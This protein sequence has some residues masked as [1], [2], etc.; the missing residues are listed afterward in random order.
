MNKEKDKDGEGA[1]RYSYLR[2]LKNRLEFK[3]STEASSLSKEKEMIREISSIN[4]ELTALSA[5]VRMDRK[6]GLVKGDIVECKAKLAELEPKIVEID[7]KLDLM[8]TDLR[9]KL[10]I[11]KRVQPEHKPHQREREDRPR[12]QP[13][14]EEI[15]LEDIAVI[16]KKDSK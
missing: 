8:Y 6:L 13:R 11:T 5:S 14:N 3:I 15:N 2:R 10:G 9:K 16:K 4:Q 1:K 7:S 12:Q